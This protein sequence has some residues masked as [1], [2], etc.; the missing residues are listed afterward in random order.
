MYYVTITNLFHIYFLFLSNLY[1]FVALFD[2]FYDVFQR[3]NYQRSCSHNN[4]LSFTCFLKWNKMYFFKGVDGKI[5][6]FQQLKKS[7]I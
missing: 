7:P 5:Y 4:D 1:D 3:P 2:V 6:S